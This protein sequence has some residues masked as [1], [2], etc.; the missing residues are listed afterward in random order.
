MPLSI[1]RDEPRRA[2]AT[3]A[4]A[5]YAHATSAASSVKVPRDAM[6]HSGTADRS[7]LHAAGRAPAIAP[8]GARQGLLLGSWRRRRA[9]VGFVFRRALGHDAVGSH[10]EAVRL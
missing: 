2:P 7:W 10:V 8:P 1:R 3:A 4:A 9:L 6:G 5:A